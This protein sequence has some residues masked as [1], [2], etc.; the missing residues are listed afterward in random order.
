M[1]KTSLRLTLSAAGSAG[2]AIL[3]LGTAALSPANAYNRDLYGYA[4]THMPNASEI[5]AALGKFAPKLNFNADPG[6]KASR[7][8]ICSTGDA[9][10]DSYKSVAVKRNGP[11]FTGYYFN[12][13]PER[14]AAGSA[15]GRQ[16]AFRS[17]GI[18]FFVF[19]SPSAA[20]KAFSKLRERA[21]SCTGSRTNSYGGD[22]NPDGS[23]NPIYSSSTRLANGTVAAVVSDGQRGVFVENDSR[24]T[25]QSDPS[26]PDL[27]D[28]YSIYAPVGDAI[29]QVTYSSN[30][31]DRVT[32]AEAAAIAELTNKAIGVWRR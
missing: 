27:N 32:K 21:K 18:S 30:Q 31:R 11:N 19:D 8:F 5:P 28:N 25:S 2:L 1:R 13:A 14:A 22:T 12:P 15:D 20:T 10:G 16:P 17:V 23:V 24:G 29:V 7:I 3:L 4:A 26:N 9:D 6:S